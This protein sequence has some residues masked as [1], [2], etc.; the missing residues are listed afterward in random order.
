MHPLCSLG[1]PTSTIFPKEEEGE[2]L[3]PCAITPQLPHSRDSMASEGKYCLEQLNSFTSYGVFVPYGTPPV[4]E[5]H[6]NI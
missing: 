4:Q 2:N 5:G 6:Q 3:V 1:A